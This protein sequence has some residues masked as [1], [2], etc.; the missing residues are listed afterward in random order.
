M[1]FFCLLVNSLVT[2]QLL[3]LPLSLL[4]EKT[5]LVQLLF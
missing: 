1:A 2:S 4:L 3:L 5:A